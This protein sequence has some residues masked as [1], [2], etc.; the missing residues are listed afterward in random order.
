[1][2]IMIDIMVIIILWIE[3][4]IRD[5][6][7]GSE[8][9]DKFHPTSWAVPLPTVPSYQEDN[10]DC[11]DDDQDTFRMILIIILIIMIRI[12]T[13]PCQLGPVLIIIL[14]IKIINRHHGDW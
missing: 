13:S 11:Q 1:M 7:E 8:M 12:P 9:T 3:V 4:L 6:E 14:T 10:S 5:K 2:I